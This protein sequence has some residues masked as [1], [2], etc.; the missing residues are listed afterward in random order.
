M[1]KFGK[2]AVH[3]D[4]GAFKNNA[5]QGKAS[6]VNSKEESFATK[7][8][9]SIEKSANSNERQAKIKDARKK[10]TSKKQKT[11][12]ANVKDSSQVKYFSRWE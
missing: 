3:Q 9:I 7:K 10:A 2:I 6:E 8:A 4:E 1:K 12:P 5:S 11:D